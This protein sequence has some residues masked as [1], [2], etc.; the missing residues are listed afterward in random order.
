[1]QETTKPDSLNTSPLDP[2]L[3]IKHIYPQ[4]LQGLAEA[5]SIHNSASLGLTPSLG[6]FSIASLIRTTDITHNILYHRDFLA[7][8]TGSMSS[9]LHLNENPL[10]QD[11]VP[12]I[13]RFALLLQTD[14]LPFT[15]RLK[16]FGRRHFWAGG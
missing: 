8:P 5:S 9:E 10:H 12:D 14:G 16:F 6:S 4:K 3:V 2:E 11:G 1:M 13:L 15:I 7:L